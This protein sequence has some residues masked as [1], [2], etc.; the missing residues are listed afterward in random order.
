MFLFVVTIDV[1]VDVDVD[2]GLRTVKKDGK[3]GKRK[4]ELVL[5]YVLVVTFR[6]SRHSYTTPYRREVC[7]YMLAFGTTYFDQGLFR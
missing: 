5:S 4:E 7:S 2:V 1:D 6:K 3:G